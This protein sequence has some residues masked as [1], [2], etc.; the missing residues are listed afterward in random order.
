MVEGTSDPAFYRSVYEKLKDLNWLRQDKSLVFVPGTG[1]NSVEH[2]APNLQ[3]AG[4]GPV[5]K[6]LVDLDYDFNKL[7]EGVEQINRYSIENYFFDPVAFYF[8]MINK[9]K[10]FEIPGIKE[11]PKFSEEKVWDLGENQIQKIVDAV[12]DKVEKGFSK[13]IR[14]MEREKQK[15]ILINNKELYYPSWF[16]QQKGKDFFGLFKK[17]FPKM[18][19]GP[20]EL[21]GAICRTRMIPLELAETIARL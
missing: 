2:W 20:D 5:I 3:K 19:F 9:G 16:L 14:H 1:K 7:S 10:A 18:T 15:V 13:S 11:I 17:A 6:G 8:L 21:T 4:L 12:L